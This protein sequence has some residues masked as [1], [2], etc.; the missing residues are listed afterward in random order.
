MIHIPSIRPRFNVFYVSEYM[1]D[2]FAVMC[3]RHS[4][5]RPIVEVH[6][7]VGR[8]SN[9]RN[10]TR[11]RFRKDYVPDSRWLCRTEYLSWQRNRVWEREQFVLICSV[12]LSVPFFKVPNQI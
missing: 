10:D 9:C 3:G 11:G 5:R 7:I 8:Q 4:E 6:T 1:P 12:A 2:I